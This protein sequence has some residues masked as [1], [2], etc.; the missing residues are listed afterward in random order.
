[1]GKRSGSPG[2]GLAG[3]SSGADDVSLHTQPGDRLFDDVPELQSDDMPDDMPPL[4]SDIE[5]DSSSNAPLLATIHNPSYVADAL[6]GG[7]R[8]EDANTG[9]E[10]FINSHL[11]QDPKLLERQIRLSA[12]KPPRPSVR[13]LGT[14]SQ[15]VSENGKKEKRSVTDFDVVLD[16]TPYLFSDA[17]TGASWTEFRTVEDSEQTKRGTILR[18]RAPGMRQDIEISANTKPTLAEWCHRYHASHA[19]LKCFTLRRRVLGFDEAKLREKLVVLVRGTNYRGHVNITFPVKQD[20]V[21]VYNDCK[22]S[23]WRL[24]PWVVW[25]CYLSFLW[26]FTWPYLFLRTKIFEVAVAD[27]PF[28]V[29]E[30]DGRKRYVSMSEDHL[31]NLWARA[32]SRAVLDKRQCALDQEDLIA[33]QTAPEEPFTNALKGAPSFLRAGINAITAVN[34]QLGWG[35][36]DH[37]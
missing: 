28:S 25:L 10:F 18:K 21:I 17:T 5:P 36:D 26:L 34:R 20:S 24:T 12:S 11:D 32:I 2:P 7:L 14:H 15:T 16:L 19:G 1:M 23:R 22:V 29:T 3:A 6:H 9:A 4:Y 31:Y 37:S 27:W 13:I 35:G 33:S 30:P 8:S